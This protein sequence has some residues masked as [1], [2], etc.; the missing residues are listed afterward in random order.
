MAGWKWTCLHEET[1]LDGN[2]HVT[3]SAVRFNQDQVVMFETGTLIQHSYLPSERN[4]LSCG[5]Y[6]PLLS[7]M[8]K[9]SELFYFEGTQLGCESEDST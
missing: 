2:G 5:E 6:L 9:Y 8:L 7:E 1:W 4:I 3:T